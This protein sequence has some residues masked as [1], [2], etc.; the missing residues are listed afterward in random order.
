MMRMVGGPRN[1]LRDL[2]HLDHERV[3]AFE[4]T[5]TAGH[6]TNP[7]VPD[8]LVTR[9]NPDSSRAVR[10]RRF[11]LNMGMGGMMAM[12]GSRGRMMEGGRGSGMAMAGIN[13]RAFDMDRI[14]EKVRLVDFEIWEA[15][16]EMM[17]HP[18][19]IHGVHFQVL[20]RGGVKP[21]IRDQGVRDTVLVKEPVELLVQFTQPASKAAPFMYHCHILEHEDNGMMGQFTAACYFS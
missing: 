9:A 15:S 6:R 18:L 2:V 4:P 14:D 7:T 16:G 20:S 13:G 11:S 12:M 5:E 17:A 19:H 8:R 1:F 21:S 3:L 10:R